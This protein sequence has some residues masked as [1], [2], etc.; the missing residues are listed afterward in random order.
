MWLT[1]LE[2]VDAAF[3]HEAEQHLWGRPH[4]VIGAPTKSSVDVTIGSYPFGFPP[5]EVGESSDS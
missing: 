5:P 4:G 2:E 1:T 3:T